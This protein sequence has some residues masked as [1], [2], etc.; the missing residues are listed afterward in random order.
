MRRVSYRT[1]VVLFGAFTFCEILSPWAVVADGFVP[2]SRGICSEYSRV[3]HR[4]GLDSLLVGM[5][6]LREKKSS[7]T[8]PADNGELS[9]GG[10]S[11]NNSDPRQSLSQPLSNHHEGSGHQ[12]HSSIFHRAV[13]QVEHRAKEKAAFGV[14]ERVTEQLSKVA[15]KG[16]FQRFGRRTLKT[17]GE[18]LTERTSERIGKRVLEGAG[19]RVLERGAE[20]AFGHAG[21]QMSENVAGSMLGKASRKVFRQSVQRHSGTSAER[22]VERAAERGLE[23]IGDRAGKHFGQRVAEQSGRLFDRS[24]G[25]MVDRAIESSGNQMS[26][27]TIRNSEA[28]LERMGEQSI[29][30]STMR[31]IATRTDRTLTRS[32]SSSG[33]RSLERTMKVTGKK[34]GARMLENGADRMVI[35]LARSLMII[36]PAVGGIFALYLFKTDVDRF[37]EEMHHRVVPSLAMFAGASIADLFDTVLHFCIFAGFLR[38]WSHHRMEIFETLSLSCAIISTVCAVAGEI[39]SFRTRRRRELSG[40][41]VCD[42]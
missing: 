22:I 1:V 30:R 10:V 37:N 34:F 15:E 11:S 38:H 33:E 26:R 24:A 31:A 25:R 28:A 36:L 9:Q 18:K 16:F 21:K 7:D 8:Q 14:A 3:S 12:D 13:H 4:G 6:F 20:R 5:S 41:I 42:A 2:V 39:I 32:F 23:R 27:R 29:K 40:M 17:T 19:D 35:R